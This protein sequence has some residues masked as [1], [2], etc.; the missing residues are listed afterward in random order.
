MRGMGAEAGFELR[1]LRTF[2]SVAERLSFTRAAEDLHI[3]QQAVSQQIKALEKTLDTTLLSRSPRTV[4][5]TPAGAVFLRDARRLLA[6]ADN[7]ARRARAA[8]LG[9]AGTLRLAYTLTA[10]WETIPVL[11]ADLGARCPDLRVEAREVFGAD[12][13]ELLLDER[14]DL[15]IAP[16]T[17]HPRTIR[18]KT[19]R[20]EVLRIAMS[21][22]RTAA[23][24]PV[25]NLS[26]LRDDQFE[27]WPREMAPGF[28]DAVVGACRAAGFEPNLDERAG[29]NTVW[30]YIAQ[31][32][33]VGLVNGSLAEQLPSGIKLMELA[34]AASKLTIHA[35][36]RRDD[37]LP[38]VERTLDALASI[39]AQRHWLQDEAPLAR[40]ASR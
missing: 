29:G 28:Y 15:A 8:A 19:I 16:M 6:A 12:V 4:E 38:V 17:S 40:P 26:S 30:G 34:P 10:A 33:G 35:L 2:V 37:E 25:V 1:Q 14:I 13:G 20:R 23:G 11:L 5:L 36:W 9:E 22:R 39:A 32:L 7:A 24:T 31:D 3:A 18:H 21:T 27:I